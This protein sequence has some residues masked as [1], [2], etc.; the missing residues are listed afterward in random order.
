[1]LRLLFL[2]GNGQKTG[3]KEQDQVQDER[4]DQAGAWVAVVIGGIHDRGYKESQS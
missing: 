4:R 2:L 3:A 1:M